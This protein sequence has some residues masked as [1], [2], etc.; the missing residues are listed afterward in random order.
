MG[1]PKTYGRDE[2]LDNVMLYWVTATA[3]SSALL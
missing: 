3:A 2:L 1:I